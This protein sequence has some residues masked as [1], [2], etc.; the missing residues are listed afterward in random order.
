MLNMQ[1]A[2]IQGNTPSN[3]REERE[4]WDTE[5][6]KAYELFAL[7]LETD[8]PVYFLVG[9]E[10]RQHLIK[11]GVWYKGARVL[12]FGCYTGPSTD[13]LAEQLPH[14]RIVGVDKSQAE[15]TKA[16][17]GRTNIR[18]DFIHVPQGE[19]IPIG[20]F[21][22]ASMTF[23]HP[24]IQN[25]E[26]LFETYQKIYD[27]LAPGALLVGL[28]LHE[29]SLTKKPENV[30]Y[31]SYG[32][33]LP[34]GAQYEDGQPFWN[35]LHRE[36]G[37]EFAFYDYCWTRATQ[38]RLLREA[39]FRYVKFQD[40]SLDNPEISDMLKAAIDNCMDA[41]DRLN[42]PEWQIPLYDLTIAIK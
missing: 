20:N 9:E 1:H 34:L 23:V 26:T 42:K 27:A 29:A 22:A 16:I 38:E 30:S 32:H 14:A 3:K 25:I 13:F 31:T 5:A 12:D 35:V 10:I 15:I 24:T 36:D 41:E 33:S 11:L 19:S 7:G 6:A 2:D 18:T 39:G 8:K 4:I 21:H 37:E 17:E 28:G 40:V